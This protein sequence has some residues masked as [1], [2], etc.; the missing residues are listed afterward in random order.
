MSAA[1]FILLHHRFEQAVRM[2]EALWHPDNVYLIHV[3]QKADDAFAGSLA[4]R[5]SKLSNVRFLPRR[6]VVWGGYSLVQVHLDAMSV[7]LE[8][9]SRWTHFVNLSGQDYPVRPQSKIMEFLAS[10]AP[11]NFIEARPVDDGVA[12]LLTG[13]LWEED[14]QK[15]TVVNRGKRQPLSGLDCP[16]FSGSGWH[17]LSRDFCRHV[18][19][20]RTMNRFVK[21]FR[22]VVASDEAFFQTALLNG[23][24]RD[25][26]VNHPFRF[27]E[28]QAPDAAYGGGIL[29]D[30][31]ETDEG[32]ELK[33][34]QRNHP[35]TIVSDD[36]ERLKG[37]PAFFARKFD[38]EVDARILDLIDG[39]LL[40]LKAPGN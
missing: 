24:F 34:N 35:R 16:L 18:C 37:Y 38:P 20:D 4:E 15:G 26:H 19:F 14:P 31:R 6:R 10:N 36:L 12:Q 8:W 29:A 1:Y 21:F 5:F 13:Y 11:M 33:P 30:I 3:D 7:L 27:I 22:R 25:T 23:E 32:M 40:D 17:M 9:D 2:V 39:E 28:L